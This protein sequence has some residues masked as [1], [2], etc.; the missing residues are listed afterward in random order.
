[1]VRLKR[2]AVEGMFSYTERQEAVFS[3]RAVIVGP[4]NAG[5][6][7]L[8][9]IIDVLAD[10]LLHKRN[11]P[12]SKTSESDHNPCIEVDL[13]LSP[14]EIDTLADFFSCSTQ[15]IISDPDMVLT[16]GAEDNRSCLGNIS[17]K[18]EWERVPKG[19]GANPRI[20]MEFPECGFALRGPL[21]TE[22]FVAEPI[23]GERLTERLPRYVHFNM[24]VK[25]I[26][27]SDDPKSSAESFFQSKDTIH[28]PVSF[29][30]DDIDLKSQ[31]KVKDLM[32]WLDI[33]TGSIALP[34]VLGTMLKKGTVHA[35]ENRNLLQDEVAEMFDHL[36]ISTAD[37]DGF[38]YRYNSELLDM[39]AYNS[40]NHTDTLKNDGSNI[41]QFLF[42]L[43]NSPDRRDT[44]RYRAIEERFRR[45]FRDQD[46]AIEPILEY[47]VVDS[48]GGGRR[49]FPRPRLAVADGRMRERL[50]L[51]QVG[52]GVRGVIYLLAAVYGTK[53][54]VV[55]LDEPG[56]NLHPA[57]LREVMEEMEEDGSNNQIL[58]TTHSPELLDYEM[59][60]RGSD[61]FHVSK[62]GGSVIL[63]PRSNGDV[64][65]WLKEERER[66]KHQI[67]V[68]AFFAHLAILVEGR[69]DQ[70]VLLGVAEYKAKKDPKYNL[71]RQNVAVIDAHGK[72]NFEKYMDLLGAYGIPCVVLAD[73]D[74]GN[75]K[76]ERLFEGRET[77]KFPP[78]REPGTG[79]DIVLVKNNL[80]S[81]MEATD[82]NAFKRAKKAGR[83]S[84][85]AAAIEFC[86]IVRE[87]DPQ[88]LRPFASFLDYC[89][90]RVPNAGGAAK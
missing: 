73:R 64:D 61:V 83:G 81:L 54:S 53:D 85:V 39:F 15:P 27:E 41:A 55:M 77:A 47:P 49:R 3:G 43:K 63:G 48:L 31:L 69:S 72:D 25:E 13:S 37:S 51:E 40:L 70:S 67:D 21:D 71:S 14:G 11:L 87:K 28:Y 9:R 45:M 58:I 24:F 2:L 1:M 10:E 56:I 65:E 30:I 57:M 52:A 35:T 6:S 60:D 32:R 26:L 76:H 90:G 36:A 62:K 84:K 89:I 38:G 78:D 17:I 79:A 34:R 20:E 22:E 80:E 23:G 82:R 19:L 75:D 44:G 74:D 16:Y 4:N 7:N 66:L 33:E 59:F 88:K 42:S 18:I 12:A 5:K 50:S 86:R 46:L 68:R 8:F 29:S